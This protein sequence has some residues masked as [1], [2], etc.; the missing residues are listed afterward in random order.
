M[1]T[2]ENQAQIENNGR[3]NLLAKLGEFVKREGVPPSSS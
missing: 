1:P 3:S 2:H